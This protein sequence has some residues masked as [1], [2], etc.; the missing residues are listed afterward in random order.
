MF[1]FGA[2]S[3]KSIQRE[4]AQ[5]FLRHERPARIF[6]GVIE[7]EPHLPVFVDVVVNFLALG[8]F[9]EQDFLDQVVDAFQFFF[10]AHQ[11]FRINMAGRVDQPRRTAYRP[12]AGSHQDRMVVAIAGKIIQRFAGRGNIVAAFRVVDVIPA[13]VDF[14]EHRKALHQRPVVAITLVVLEMFVG[15]HHREIPHLR[16]VVLDGPQ[17]GTFVRERQQFGN[18]DVLRVWIV[19][20]RIHHGTIV[21][22][23]AREAVVPEKAAVHQREQIQENTNDEHFAQQPEQELQQDD[24][25][26]E[27]QDAVDGYRP[28]GIDDVLV[29][30]DEHRNG[31]Q[32]IQYQDDDGIPG[33]FDRELFPDFVNWNVLEIHRR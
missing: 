20:H 7:V 19:G 15:G 26:D 29:D 31:N 10:A 12:D 1:W 4:C 9:R 18:D 3:Q 13:A 24:D 14:L 32:D 23:N 8:F 17:D 2:V 6:G 28:L 11:N 5:D 16:I 33:F 27:K 21:I 25:R 22:V 30:D